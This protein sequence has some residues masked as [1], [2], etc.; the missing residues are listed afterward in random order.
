VVLDNLIRNAW[1]YTSRHAAARIE[2]GQEPG[3]N[4]P[5]YFIRDDGAGFDVKYADRLFGAF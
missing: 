5:V 4:P 3:A 1:K 2:L